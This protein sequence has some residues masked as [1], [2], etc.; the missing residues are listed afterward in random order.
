MYKMLYGVDYNAI[1][2]ILETID[3][4]WMGNWIY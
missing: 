4:I 1:V 3:G 2:T